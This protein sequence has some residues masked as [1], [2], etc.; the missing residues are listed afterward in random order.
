MT[1]SKM[2]T[3]PK[4]EARLKKTTIPNLEIGPGPRQARNQRR[5]SPSPG[6]RTRGP[7][8]VTRGERKFFVKCSP[9]M[10]ME[11]RVNRVA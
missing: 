11:K 2:A 10:Q 4:L 7:L 8:S 6:L 5:I 9:K 3:C 1:I